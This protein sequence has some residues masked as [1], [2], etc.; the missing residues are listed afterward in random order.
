[1][2]PNDTIANTVEIENVIE[3]DNNNIII[4]SPQSDSPTE[5]TSFKQQP[6]T[7][8]LFCMNCSNKGH[9]FKSCNEPVNSYGLLCFYKK[10]ILVKDNTNYNSDNFFNRKTKKGEN[11]VKANKFKKINNVHNIPN[12]PNTHYVPNMTTFKILKRNESISHTLKN[13]L[14]IK[15]NNGINNGKGSNGEDIID[16]THN[17]HHEIDGVI[18]T[19]I[20][21]TVDNT[22]NVEDIINTTVNNDTNNDVYNFNNANTNNTN[23]NNTN[24]N[25]TNTPHPKMKEIAIQKVLLVQRRNTIGMIEFVRGKYDV[26]NLDYI[27]RLF[28]MMTFDEKKILRDYDSFDMIRTLIGLKREFNY[29]GEYDDAKTK[30]HTLKQNPDGDLVHSLLEKSYTKWASPE[31]GVPKGRRNNKEFDIEC[32]IRE[33]AEETGIKYHNINVFRNIKPLSEIYRGIN[34]VIYK[35]IYYIAELKDTPEVETNIL[36]VE[37]AGYLNSE[38]SNVKLFNLTEVHKIIRPYYMSKLNAIKKGFQ[39]INCLNY[40]F[41]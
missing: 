5:D 35:H 3:I 4:E 1:M 24:T 33:F 37:K 19:M 30:F 36:N 20:D 8:E 31:W 9:S 29:R 12:A 2:E 34:G 21:N 15:G 11:F 38:I 32:A 18:D 25:N 16:N 39:I 10:K 40:Y 14:G 13:M 22:I 17:T 7:N 27:V 23:T 6:Q 26:T 28:N 41:E